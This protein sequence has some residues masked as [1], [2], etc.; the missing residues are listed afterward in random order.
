MCLHLPK[1]RRV[2]Q[3]LLRVLDLDVERE[4]PDSAGAAAPEFVRVVKTNSNCRIQ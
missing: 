3:R 4:G 1:S 2:G